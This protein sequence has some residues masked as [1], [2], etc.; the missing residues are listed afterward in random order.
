MSGKFETFTGAKGKHYFRL[1]A[2][3]GIPILA[4]QGYADKRGCSNGIKSVQK[5]C[6][7]AN[8]FEKKVA[9]DGRV[10]FNL[11]A[12]NGQVVAKSQMYKSRSGM[13]NG[14]KSIMNNAPG[15]SVVAVDK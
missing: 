12:S 14:I 1:K 4:S 15:A 2:S 7:D 13:N 10:F 8:C 5:H 9:K 3:N 11:V 6:K